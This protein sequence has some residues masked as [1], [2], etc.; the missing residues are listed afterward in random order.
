[1]KVLFWTPNFKKACWKLG[2]VWHA[3]GVLE[4]SWG[5]ESSKQQLG[6]FTVEHSCTVYLASYG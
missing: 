2:L 5:F 3:T 4:V 6:F 1:M